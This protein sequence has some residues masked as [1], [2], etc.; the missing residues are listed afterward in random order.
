MKEKCKKRNIL[1]YT[2]IYKIKTKKKTETKFV[3]KLCQGIIKRKWASHFNC[4][5]ALSI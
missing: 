1:N 2:A 3:L 4:V 5:W